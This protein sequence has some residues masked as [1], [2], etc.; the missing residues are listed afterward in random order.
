MPEFDVGHIYKTRP[1]SQ[2]VRPDPTHILDL[3]SDPWPDPTRP[4]GGQQKP[5]NL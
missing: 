2:K 3:M 1:E 5:I 4:N